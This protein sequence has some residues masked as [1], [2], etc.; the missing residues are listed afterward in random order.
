MKK[1]PVF[2]SRPFGTRDAKLLLVAYFDPNGIETIPEGIVAWQTLSR[3]EV[4]LINLWP[5]RAGRL[6]LPDD[7]D[8]R[9]YEGLIIHPTISYFPKTVLNLDHDLPVDISSFEGVKML[10]KQDEQ[11][12]SGELAPL[13]RDKAFDIVFTCLPES[14][15]EKVYTRSIIGENCTMVRTLTGYVSPIMRQGPGK[16]TKDLGLTYRGSIQPLEFGRL[17][18]EKRGI[19]YDMVGAL[20]GRPDIRFDISSRWEDRVS[21][22]AWEDFLRRSNVVLGVESGS[23][24]FDFDGSVVAWCRAYAERHKGEDTATYDYY[25]RAHDEFLHTV[26][27]NVDYAQISPRHFEATAAG[28]AQLLYEGVYSDLFHPHR[29]FFPLRRDLGNI[30]AVIDFLKDG[31]AQTRMAECAFEEIILN[32]DNWYESFVVRADAAIDRKLVEKGLRP[33][34]GAG[35]GASVAP[36]PVARP[37]AYVLCAHD[38]K[39]DPRV[40]WFANSLQATHDVTVIGTYPFNKVGESTTTE[41]DRNGVRIVRVERTRHEQNWIA[42]SGE[43]REGQPSHARFLLAML[44]DY[45][46]MPTELL[47]A[48]LGGQIAHDV[49]IE[50]FRTICEYMV[51]TNAALLD[52]I[53]Q[54]GPPNVVVGV[55][56][57]ALF[58][59]AICKEVHGVPSVFDAHEYWPYSYTDFQ[60]WEIEFWGAMEGRLASL[61]DIN[62]GVTPQLCGLMDHEYGTSFRSLPNAASRRDGNFDGLEKDFDRRAG[63]APLKVLYQGGFAEGRGLEEVLRAWALVKSDAHLMLRGPENAYRDRIIAYAS[64]LGLDEA[65]VSFPPPVSEDELIARAR[66]ADVGLIPYNPT[67]FG[68]RYCCPNKLSQYAAAGLPI[69]SSSTEFV[70]GMVRRNDMGF[71][72]DINDAASVAEQIDWMSANRETLVEKGRN[73][74]AVFET[75]FN[76]EALGA[77][78]FRDIATLSADSPPAV[79]NFDAIDYQ[80]RQKIR[81]NA[82]SFSRSQTGGDSASNDD[83]LTF[84]A[85]ASVIAASPFFEYPN[86]ASALLR[87]GAS[88]YAAALPDTSRVCWIEFALGRPIYVDRATVGWLDEENRATHY[89]VLGRETEHSPWVVLVEEGNAPTARMNHAFPRSLCRYVRIE[90]EAYVGQPRMLIRRFELKASEDQSEALARDGDVTGSSGPLPLMQGTNPLKFEAGA[91]V[92]ASSAFS[93]FPNDA[94]YVLRKE[95]HGGYAAALDTSDGH[96]WIEFSLAGQSVVNGAAVEWYNEDN[97]VSGYRISTRATPDSEWVTVVEEAS[98]SELLNRHSFAG[99][100]CSQVRLETFEYV[101]QRRMLLRK[102]ELTTGAASDVA[103]SVP[104]VAASAPQVHANV[105]GLRFIKRLLKSARAIAGTN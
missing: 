90:A 74:R 64:S 83:L 49:E 101:G 105:R 71:V 80:K 20:Q 54:F 41:M 9:Q 95:V 17:G 73:A 5:G 77:E 3:H 75:T 15:H 50:R 35:A 97:R 25:R 94:A 32:R 31:A 99:V 14:E 91:S 76:W 21:G 27:G 62:I 88:G 40:D 79:P 67:W 10:M 103:S 6:N 30:D 48:K 89:R 59:A 46:G 55:D 45:A 93:P 84:D 100:F 23:N 1:K 86:D 92:L 72:V 81:R 38:P 19:G 36:A 68:Y 104:V 87:K 70:A 13:V 37:T 22:A 24:I 102:F 12:H 82:Y 65:K 96:N 44:A 43:L 58:A 33:A 11:V 98:A 2:G 18:Y 63:A 60:H 85:G 51:N 26:E 47:K 52:A 69:L 42:T 29:H 7:L 34:A 56:L 4:Q 57:E 53:E 39:I 16:V 28:A 61:M 78:L 8:L 66:E